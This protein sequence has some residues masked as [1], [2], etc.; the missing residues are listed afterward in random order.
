MWWPDLRGLEDSSSLGW[1]IP[2]AVAILI[3][4]GGALL[5]RILGG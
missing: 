2:L 1:L 5:A 4:L 3:G